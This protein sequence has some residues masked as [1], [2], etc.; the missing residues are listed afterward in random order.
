MKKSW[1]SPEKQMF[2]KFNHLQSL[3]S[4]DVQQKVNTGYFLDRLIQDNCLPQSH[5]VGSSSLDQTMSNDEINI[6][7][8]RNH[9]CEISAITA[10]KQIYQTLVPPFFEKCFSD[11]E[12]DIIHNM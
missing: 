11:T 1:I 4:F 10:N 7:I 8:I 2:T 5:A 12:F 9:T 3:S 6:K